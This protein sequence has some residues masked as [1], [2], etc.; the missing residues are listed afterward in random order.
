MIRQII[1]SLCALI[2]A[3]ALAW[4]I[5][6]TAPPVPKKE[7][8]EKKEAAEKKGGDA[9]KDADEGGPKV[10]LTETQ[11]KN[12]NLG[13]E[14]AASAKVKKML[15]LFGKIAANEEHIAHVM[16]R[17]PGVVKAVK[18]RLGDKIEQGEILAV[19]ESNESLRTYNITSEIAGTVIQKDVSLGEFVKDDKAIFT[20]ADLSTVWVDLN[21]Y[22]Q[23]FA[24]LHAGLPVWVRPEE[25]AALIETTLAYLSP[26]GAESTQTMLARVVIPNP[27][28][29]LRPGLFVTAQVMTG[30]VDA[31]VTVKVGALQTLGETTVVFVENG[32][33]FEARTVE[34]GERDNELVEVLSGLLP[35]DKYVAGNSF[36]LKA[37]LKK[38]EAKDSD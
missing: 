12:A 32:D 38:N 21:V 34:L 11:R 37:E 19:V 10:K 27:K 35:G 23:D 1:L 22:R 30:E 36:I 20:V 31:P 26:F 14:E 33:V 2:V 13:I 17:F 3:S 25:S 15:P 5:I 29:D 28:G 24:Q 7:E 6:H 8:A 4:R 18:K 16:P 9:D